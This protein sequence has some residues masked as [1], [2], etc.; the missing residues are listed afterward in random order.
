MAQSNFRRE[1]MQRIQVLTGELIS[2]VTKLDS[3]D[4]NFTI[5]EDF[6]IGNITNNSY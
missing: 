2:H 1:I 5:A 3:D 4:E 6:I